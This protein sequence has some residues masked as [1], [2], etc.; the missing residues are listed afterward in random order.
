MRRRLNR[1]LQPVSRYTGP[2]V[3]CRILKVC[4]LA[5]VLSVDEHKGR[6]VPLSEVNRPYAAEIG[7][8][9]TT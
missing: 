5:Q 4:L 8:A 9:A 2:T 3:R 1:G 7:K 6:Y